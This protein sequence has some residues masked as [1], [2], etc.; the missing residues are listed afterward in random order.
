MHLHDEDN[1]AS[2]SSLSIEESNP[3]EQFREYTSGNIGASVVEEVS[4]SSSIASYMAV[5]AKDS[6]GLIATLLLDFGVESEEDLRFVVSLFNVAEISLLCLSLFVS[7][8]RIFSFN[9]SI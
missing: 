4:K 1:L 3:L 9:L 8:F 6:A 7:I 2:Y 5:C